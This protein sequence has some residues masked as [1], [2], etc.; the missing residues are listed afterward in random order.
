MRLPKPLPRRL[1][2]EELTT[3]F[4]AIKRPR[5]R[6]PC[7]LMLRSGLR[8]EEVAKLSLETL[9]RPEAGSSSAT[10]RPGWTESC[11]SARRASAPVAVVNLPSS[12]NRG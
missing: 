11:I 9:D 8:V 2:E 10:A 5:D 4:D 3:L 6:A 7:L 1:K 12:S